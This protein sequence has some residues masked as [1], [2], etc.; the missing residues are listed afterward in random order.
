MDDDLNLD[1]SELWPEPP[2]VSPDANAR[3]RVAEQPEG[4]WR[5]YHIG[6]MPKPGD[7]V[8]ITKTGR[9]GEVHAVDEDGDPIAQF[10]GWPR[11]AVQVHTSKLEWLEEPEPVLDV[12]PRGAAE[13]AKLSTIGT[14]QRF[15]PEVLQIGRA[16]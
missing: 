15:V 4:V 12:L 2:S 16:H 7:V 9:R 3:V 14:L 10:D 11:H 6:R 5:P 8:R 1:G 13:V